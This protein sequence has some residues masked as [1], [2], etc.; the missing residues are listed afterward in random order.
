[1]SKDSYKRSF[2]FM[3]IEKRRQMLEEAISD[4][5][6]YIIEKFPEYG[7]GNYKLIF[8]PDGDLCILDQT[9]DEEIY[10]LPDGSHV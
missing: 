5:W 6:Q 7:N 2:F 3:L 9:K 8:S 4:Y 1:M 10:E